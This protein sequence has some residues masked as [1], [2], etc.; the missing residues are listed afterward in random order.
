MHRILP[1]LLVW[2]FA[3]AFSGHLSAEE[4]KTPAYPPGWMPIKWF[5]AD[6]QWDDDFSPLPG[7]I[8]FTSIYLTRTGR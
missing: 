8:G 4:N 3:L 6:E 5:E 7:G 2:A 1:K